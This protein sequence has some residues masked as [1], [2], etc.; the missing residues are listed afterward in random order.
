MTA[1]MQVKRRAAVAEMKR[2]ISDFMPTF[3]K[4]YVGEPVGLPPTT[5]R[6]IAI[7]YV[8]EETK[9]KTLGNVMV[10]EIWRL[11]CYWRPR[12]EE[13][14]RESLELEVWDVV[15]DVQEAFR[16]DSQLDGNVS[17]MEISLPEVGW[18]DVGEARYRTASFDLHLWE[19]EAEAIV[20]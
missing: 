6:A 10:T 14:D 5:D 9:S 19:L 20:A 18:L 16:S 15:R 11:M 12:V 3:E 8:G 13:A 1:A 17:D 7:W 2:L 4:I